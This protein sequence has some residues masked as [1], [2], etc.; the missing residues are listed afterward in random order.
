[1]TSGNAF[2]KARCVCVKLCCSSIRMRFL[3]TEIESTKFT[4]SQG[5]F[6]YGPINDYF[7]AVKE[8]DVKEFLRLKYIHSA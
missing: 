5:K 4:F 7:W 1:M 6:W 8:D 2:S 3:E